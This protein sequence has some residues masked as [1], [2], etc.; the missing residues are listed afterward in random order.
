MADEEQEKREEI[1][2]GQGDRPIGY[3]ANPIKEVRERELK[4]AEDVEKSAK[5]HPDPHIQKIRDDAKAQKDAEFE[6]KQKMREATLKRNEEAAKLEIGPNHPLHPRNT[7]NPSSPTSPVTH[8]P[9]IQAAQENLGEG[10][11]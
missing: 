10:E 11:P 8:D 3:V 9:A 1:E 4:A 5:Q 2:E 7:G 6:H